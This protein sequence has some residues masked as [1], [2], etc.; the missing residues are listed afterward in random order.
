MP[1]PTVLV[2]RHLDVSQPCPP[3]VPPAAGAAGPSGAGGVVGG[4]PRLCQGGR[5]PGD[6]GEGA[7]AV[8]SGLGSPRL[9]PPRGSIACPLDSLHPRGTHTAPAGCG[10][11][12]APVSCLGRRVR[13]WTASALTCALP[14]P[15]NPDP[16]GRLPLRPSAPGG[17]RAPDSRP[18]ASARPLCAQRRRRPEAQQDTEH[19]PLARA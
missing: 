1:A 7:A 16:P 12:W 17:V 15:R 2:H 6:E 5:L 10:R 4:R 13:S 3:P 14:S 11:H 19:T 18:A 9:P 8:R